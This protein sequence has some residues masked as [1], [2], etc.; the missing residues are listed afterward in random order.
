[1][2]ELPVMAGCLLTSMLMLSNFSL[3]R[4]WSSFGVAPPTILG[5]R[6]A[7]LVGWWAGVL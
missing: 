4:R 3:G 6:A 5:S 2:S 1:V 7:G